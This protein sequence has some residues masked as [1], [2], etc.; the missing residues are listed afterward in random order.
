MNL[1]CCSALN[2]GFSGLGNES[3][4]GASA[5]EVMIMLD[6]RL[7]INLRGTTRLEPCTDLVPHNCF[8]HGL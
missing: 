3:G 5:D 4:C 1:E 2:S 6:K 8:E 7:G